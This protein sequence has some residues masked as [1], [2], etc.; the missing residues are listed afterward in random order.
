MPQETIKRDILPSTLN[1]LLARLDHL[2]GGIDFD[3]EAA[4]PATSEIMHLISAPN[5]ELYR[6][7][8]HEPTTGE[9]KDAEML[10]S[11]LR[12]EMIELETA[13]RKTNRLASSGSANYYIPYSC[14]Q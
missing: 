6:A 9:A 5:A 13:A 10:V 2:A 12:S 7:L 11:N 4:I 8:G 1:V 14:Y 3:Y